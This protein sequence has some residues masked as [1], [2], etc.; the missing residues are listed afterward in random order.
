MVR[1][2]VQKA[3]G[4]AV[5]PASKSTAFAAAHGWF[6][7]Y[8]SMGD[9]CQADFLQDPEIA[10]EVSVV[11]GRTNS[12]SD[13]A[14]VIANV[15]EFNVKFNT[16]QGT[17]DILGS[18]LAANLAPQVLPFATMLQSIPRQSLWYSLISLPAAV[19]AVLWAMSDQALPRSFRMMQGFGSD[20]LR[21][22]SESGELRLVRFHW[23]PLLGRHFLLREE[24]SQIAD[25]DPEY[26]RR[27]LYDA[28]DRGHYPEWELGVQLLSDPLAENAVKVKPDLST[29]TPIGRMVLD[30]NPK[31]A[32]Q[33]V[34]QF[35]YSPLNVV[36]GIESGADTVL[37]NSDSNRSSEADSD[38][39]ASG[40]WNSL[41]LS[42][43]ARVVLALKFELSNFATI[44]TQ[45]Q[46]LELLAKVAAPLAEQVA[47]MLG[48]SGGAETLG[49]PAVLRVIDTA[50]AEPPVDFIT[51]E[52]IRS[53][54]IALLVSDGID[55]EILN[56]LRL[57][58]AE[59]GAIAKV[60]APALEIV[61]KGD[62]NSVKADADISSSDS[63][64]FD[65]VIVCDGE[66]PQIP[67]E[68]AHP[69][70]QFIAQ[71]HRHQ[72]PIIAI[73]A[74]GRAQL[75]AANIELDSEPAQGVWCAERV[76][77]DF[78]LLARV[79]IATHRFWDR[80]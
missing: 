56:G 54:R 7:I 52:G 68:Q 47:S 24:A 27:D 11:F 13:T 57:A 9:L 26:L 40:F 22:T 1:S 34:R 17:L 8:R 67:A 12:L 51:S 3:A 60:L 10:V 19:P 23:K 72:K 21:M 42:E 61:C 37:R 29:I 70:T 49:R 73:G 16:R 58:M 55:R 36:P 33:D 25:L 20:A 6:K 35:T 59:E 38:S 2:S 66:P 77:A 5:S 18:N 75:S 14:D 4:N 32:S 79:L 64:L 78:M 74:R 62:S 80:R 28:I 45:R 46:F 65:A 76:D 44:N 43:R 30:R 15:H 41:T 69:L 71:A 39:L 53:R 50:K 63:V 48:I 31:L